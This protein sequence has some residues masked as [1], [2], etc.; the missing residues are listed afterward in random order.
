[1]QAAPRTQNPQVNIN[2][3]TRNT[4]TTKYF[5]HLMRKYLSNKLNLDE[6]FALLKLNPYFINFIHPHKWQLEHLLFQ[7]QF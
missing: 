4:K 2:E 3:P 1:M 7:S 6:D 5:E